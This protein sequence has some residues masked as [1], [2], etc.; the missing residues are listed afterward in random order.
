MKNQTVES[1]R[2]SVRPCAVCGTFYPENSRE[3]ASLIDGLFKDVPP[4]TGE[5][6]RG[7][8]APHAGYLYSG[9]T[10]A[11]AYGRLRGCTYDAVLIVSPSHREHFEGVSVFNGE[12]YATPLGVVP[13]DGDLREQLVGA[14]EEIRLSGAGHQS[15]HAVEVQLPFLQRALGKFVFVPLVIGHQTPETCFN[16]GKSI[17]GVVGD[18]NV[19]LIASTDLSH[20]YSA[21][22]AHRMDTVVIDDL[23]AFDEQA[24]MDH[25]ERGMAEACGGGPAVAVL[26][27]LRHL[28][29]SRV[30]I[31][32][33]ATS[34]DVTGDYGSVVGYVGA[35]AV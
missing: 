26:S 33:Y 2:G 7:I 13:V 11:T 29:S 24:L 35:V 16:L 20:F 27:A 4:H 21:D 12:G 32:Q 10:A 28:G 22:I 19:L 8:I 31:L 25:L 34:G 6:I 15:E 30:D 14:S 1:V 17:A 18:R 5:R 23:R 3:L 9:P